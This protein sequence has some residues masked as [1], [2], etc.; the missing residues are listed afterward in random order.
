MNDAQIWTMIGAFTALMIGMLTVISTLFVRV[1]RA[2]IG[3]LRSEMN[4]Q[5][6]GLR[7]EMNARFDAVNV[8]MDG[9]DR[10]VQAL[11]KRTFGL[12]RE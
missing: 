9:L 6:G 2:E 8:R 7:N 4:G 1:V 10:D 12:D 5:I 3:G 11:V